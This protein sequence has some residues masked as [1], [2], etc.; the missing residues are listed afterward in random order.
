MV[1]MRRVWRIL[2][3]F[4]PFYLFTF[5]SSAQTL[6]EAPKNPIAFLI[7]ALEKEAQTNLRGEVLEKQ[8]FPPRANPD[9]TRTELPAPPP[10]SAAWIRKN[11][12]ATA[13]NGENIAGRST[14]RIN[15]EPQ[16]SNA[17][18]FTLWI[19]QKWLLRLAV[20]ERDS[21]GDI[22]FDARFSSVSNPKPRAQAR[23]LML[24]E[25]KP[26]LE[27]FVQRETGLQLPAGFNIFDLRTRSIGKNNLPAL[28]VR[29]SN[30]I[31]VLVLIFAPIRTGNTSRI[32]SKIIGNGFIWIIGNL[33]RA[34]LEK[35]ASS[36]KASL[37]LMV[38]LSSF[39]NLR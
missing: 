30:G 11:Y 25:A 24:L 21:S 16:T 6:P 1:S 12:Y 13:E 38:L 17:P 39:Q 34:E 35:T 4:L 19:D 2:F 5:L 31:S 7:R 10:L 32:V 28:E 37:D 15:L 8:I 23:Q 26:K 33:P 36:V 20:Q 29:A 14:W 18:S 27:N 9:Q 3:T 22:T